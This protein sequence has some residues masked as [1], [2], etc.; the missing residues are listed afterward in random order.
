MG[1][2]W[3]L[4]NNVWGISRTDSEVY[5]RVFQIAVRGGGENPPLP[6]GVGES[7]ILLGRIFLLDEGN[8]RRSDFDN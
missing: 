6:V 4:G 7:E 3:D 5:G 2:E 8:L 1:S